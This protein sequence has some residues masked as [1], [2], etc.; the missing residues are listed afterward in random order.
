MLSEPMFNKRGG[1]T[2]APK[3]PCFSVGDE[4]E[5]CNCFTKDLQPT[6]IGALVWDSAFGEKPRLLGR[7]G[8]TLIETLIYS[9]LLAFFLVSSIIVTNQILEDNRKTKGKLEVSGEAEF[10]MGKIS[11]VLADASSTVSPMANATSTTL[12]INKTNYSSNPLEFSLSGTDIYLKRGSASST[13]L[14]SQRVIITKFL[15]THT[16]EATNDQSIIKVELNV[17]NKLNVDEPPFSASTTLATSFK[18]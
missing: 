10:I 2:R 15:A 14:N 16:Y 4:T 7:G 12:S 17:E 18:I 3:A 5:L 8:F 1:F 9:A 13:R 11:Y 6:S